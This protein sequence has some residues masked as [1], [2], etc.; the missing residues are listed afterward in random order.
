MPKYDWAKLIDHDV[1]SMARQA[2]SHEDDSGGRSI[3]TR[4]MPELTKMQCKGMVQCKNQTYRIMKIS[5][6]SYAVIRILDDTPVG[7]FEFSPKL[8]V[9]PNGVAHELLLQIA[10]TALKQATVSWVGPIVRRPIDVMVPPPAR[11]S[12][13]CAG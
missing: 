9:H 2:S 13:D 4:G 5:R 10:M 11:D 7:E 6:R 1:R 3:T 12:V 8:R